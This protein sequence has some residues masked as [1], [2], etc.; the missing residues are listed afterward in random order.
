MEALSNSTVGLRMIVRLNWDRLL[1]AGV[2]VF[3]LAF[4][5]WL[6]KILTL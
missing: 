5:A 4:G 1:Y 6:G 3:A 2:I